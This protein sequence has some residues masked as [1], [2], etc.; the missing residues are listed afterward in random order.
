M[1]L[2]GIEQ[3]RSVEWGKNYLWSVRFQ[4]KSPYDL[5]AP[6]DQ[7]FPAIEIEENIS[8]LISLPIEAYMATYKIPK[9]TSVFD[10][11]L[12]FMDDLNHTVFDW[13]D[14]W[15]VNSLT[16]FLISSNW[17]FIFKE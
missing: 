14:D 2:T 12:T 17:V 4:A 10:V 8:T 15:V 16:T 6:F 3:L 7:W 13:L 11:R 5:K 1:F 9:S